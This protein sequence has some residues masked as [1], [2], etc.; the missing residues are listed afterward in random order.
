[1]LP[2]SP[3]PNKGFRGFRELSTASS[4]VSVYNDTLRNP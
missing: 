4:F 3:I 2:T 1:M